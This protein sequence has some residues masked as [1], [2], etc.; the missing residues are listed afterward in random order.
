MPIKPKI[1]YEMLRGIGLIDPKHINEA[2]HIQR[3]TRMPLGEI[4]K[5]KG[6]IKDDKILDLVTAQLH[7]KLADTNNIIIGPEVIETIPANFAFK[8]HIIPIELKDDTIIIAT[9]NV[10][11]FLAFDNF[12]AFFNRDIEGILTYESH[13]TH[14]LDKYYEKKDDLPINVLVAGMEDEEKTDVQA[15]DILKKLTTKEKDD[16]PVVKL[17]GL[18]ISE[19]VRRRASDIHIEPLE[20]NLRIRYRIDGVLQEVQ[21]PPKKL[22]PSVISRVKILA[23]MDI[24]EKRLP[25]DGRIRIKVSDRE[26]DL[27]VSTLPASYGESVVLRILDKTS[28]LLSLED[29]GFDHEDKGIFEKLIK[30]PHGILLVTGPTG[31]GKTTTLY[32]SLNYINK[33]DRKLITVEDPVEYQITGVNQVNVKPQIN[34]TFSTGLRSILRQA[35]DVIMIGEIRDLEAAQ[36]AIQ[37]SLTGH[38][39]FS[40]LHTNDAPGAIT[41]LIDMGI[42]PYL[43]ASALEA[44]L[45]QRLVRVICTGCKTN[46]KPSEEELMAMNLTSEQIKN[47][48]FSKGEG[49]EECNHTGYRGR[50]GIFELLTMNDAIRELVFENVPTSVIKKRAREMGML[51]LRDDGIRKVLKGITTVS[52]VLRVTQQDVV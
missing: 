36:I 51:T 41:R 7:I 52:E 15:Q 33:P 42:K 40:T 25:Q 12:R 1:I 47:A 46:H 32:A 34:L 14:L 37:A 43:V 44:A 10:F 3:N 35:P 30:K 5:S 24:A 20:E 45:A 27:R 31:S 13:I 22:Q 11:N 50:T 9:D 29:L 28:F 16:T 23:G 48:Q 17:V 19:A 49:C 21:A 39:V 6:Y 4:L 8:H 38:L 2:L 26:L 18:L